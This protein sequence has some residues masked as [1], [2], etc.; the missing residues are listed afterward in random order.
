MLPKR[1]KV[2][3]ETNMK[4]K[5]PQNA[6]LSLSKIAFDSAWRRWF[7][8]PILAAVFSALALQARAGVVLTTIHS[9]GTFENGRELRN[10]LA[11]GS[12]GYFYGTASDGG[13]NGYGTVFKISTNGTLTNLY[14]FTG[15][16]DGGYPSGAMVQGSDGYFYGTTGGDNTVF[17]SGTVFK[18]STNG[19]LATLYSFTGGYPNGLARGADGNFY[20]TT[21]GGGAHGQ[22]SI[23]KISLDGTFSILYSFTGGSDGSTLQ[24]PLVQGSDG[25]FYGT[26]AFGGQDV[27][28]GTNGGGHGTVFQ[29]ST[30]GMLTTLYSFTGGNDGSFPVALVQGGDGNFYGTTYYGGTSNLGT[31]FKI[32]SSGVYAS[33]YSFTGGDDGASPWAGLVLAS[34]GDL[35]G[36]TQ[37]GGTNGGGTVFTI[38]AN[39]ALTSLYAFTGSD[40]TGPLAPLIQASDGYFYGVTSSAVFKISASGTFATLYTFTA[41]DGSEPEAGLVLGSDGYFYGTTSSGG[42]NGFGTVFKISTNGTLTSLYTFTGGD[43]GASPQ[44]ALV[45]G[46]DG[47]FY[48]TT[49]GV[50]P[51]DAGSVFN[52][53]SSGVYTNLYLFTGGNDGGFPN[54]LVQGPDGY[55]YGT[56]EGSF[57]D[58]IPGTVFKISPDGMLTTLYSFTNNYDRTH[59]LAAL[60]LGGDGYFYGTTDGG[61]TNGGAGTVFRIGTNGTLATLYSFTGG[62]DGASPQAALVQGSDGNFYGMTSYGGVNVQFGTAYKISTNGTLTTLYSFTGGNDGGYPLAAL[63]QASDGYFYGTTYFGGTYDAGTVFGID[64]NGALTTLYSFTSGNDGGY[65]LTTLVQGSDGNFYGTTSGGGENQAGT[66]F[67][68]TIVPECQAVTPSGDLVSLSWSTQ[69]GASYQLQYTSELSSSNWAN[70]G[71]AVTATNSTLTLTDSV[72]NASQR[73]YRLALKP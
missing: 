28:P 30:N 3:I 41:D 35:Y 12:D 50:G 15:G 9:F 23:F 64:S 43:D 22:G 58:L 65:P 38:S 69:R 70:L 67:R 48:G 14:S 54:G 52:I 37:S 44:A 62:N 11:Q 63:V 60:T 71:T 1:L 57:F 45:E 21:S 66:V 24:A 73:F 42:A 55:F 34:D 59:P 49:F 40:G 20:G 26:T 36:V 46:A 27:L 61:G 13:A 31:I 6:F 25:Y 7:S 33:L 17:G 51:N 68:L 10:A 29:V 4:Q 39:G 2:N 47:N 5:L 32:T 16:S 72:T 53:S 56:T 18:I 8:T 19:T